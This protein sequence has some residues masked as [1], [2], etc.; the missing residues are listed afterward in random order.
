MISKEKILSI[1]S[2]YDERKIK[3]ATICSHSS[4]QIFHGARE[5]GVKTIGICLEKYKKTYDSFPY[6]KPHEYI[7]VDSYSEIPEKELVDENAVIIPHG[8]FVEYV[9]RK[10]ENLAVPMFGNRMSLLW[11]GDRN[12]L[13]EWMR[14]AGLHIPKIFNPSEI[15]RPCIVKLPGAKGGKG[16][17]IVSSPEEFRRKVKEKE[18]IIQE[19]ISGVRVYPHYF[20]SPI[21]KEGYGV[22]GGALELMSIDK[23]LE[24]NI[25]ESYRATLAGVKIEPS[26]T[27]IGNEPITLRESL[28]REIME[29]GARV[30]ESSYKLFGGLTGPF[31]VEM[32][33]TDDLKFYAFE[34]SARIVAGTNLYPT[35][36]PYSCY[37]YNKP[38]STGRRIAMEIKRAVKLKKLE[39]V[40]Y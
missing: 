32:I 14:H 29:M 3:I 17:T 7:I 8:S 30:V 19:Y 39:R 4:L 6:G 25:D 12:K 18:F 2:G 15:D 36:S 37:L 1:L 35:G 13:F 28:V 33:C 27:V 24:S 10:L 22:A 40:V 21:S 31:C 23:R 38:V 20:F 26:F 34:I 9:G 11:E 16:Y 5:E